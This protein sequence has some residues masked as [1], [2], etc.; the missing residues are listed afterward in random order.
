MEEKKGVDR[1]TGS[2]RIDSPR[3]KAWE[4][5]EERMRERDREIFEK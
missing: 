3:K 1:Q 2:R 4:R 5:E